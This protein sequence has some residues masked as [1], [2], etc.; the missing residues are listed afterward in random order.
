MRKPVLQDHDGAL[1]HTVTT[2]FDAPLPAVRPVWV[3]RVQHQMPGVAVVHLRERELDATVTVVEEQ[4]Q[5]IADD[6]LAPVVRH[7]GGVP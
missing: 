7:I 5:R 2:T 6:L 1:S 3:R 4:Q